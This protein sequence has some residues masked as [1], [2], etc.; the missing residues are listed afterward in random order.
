MNSVLRTISLTSQMAAPFFCGALMD[1]LGYKWTG[2][3]IAAWNV[4]SVLAE[5]TLLELI[6]RKYPALAKKINDEYKP[7]DKGDNSADAPQPRKE[8]KSPAK[9]VDEILKPLKD[10]YQAWKVY[11]THPVRNAGLGLALLYMTVLGFDSITHG[12]ILTQGVSNTVVGLLAAFSAV[13]GILGS[14]AYPHIKKRIGLERT[15][16]IG[17][18]FLV[19]TSSLAVVSIFLRGSPSKVCMAQSSFDHAMSCCECG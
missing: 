9:T 14:L 1:L 4:A 5:Y 3:F 18:F 16:L 8:E 6:Y 15:G 2:L 13:V 11:F 12:Y 7:V 19:S 10:S 17:M